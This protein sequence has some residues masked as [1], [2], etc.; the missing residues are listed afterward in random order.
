MK[1]LDELY[2]F[3][4]ELQTQGKLLNTVW[5]DTEMMIRLGSDGLSRQRFDAE[6][7]TIS[8]L[9]TS[10]LQRQCDQ[11]FGLLDSRIVLDAFCSPSQNVLK[12]AYLA[13]TVNE[14]DPLCL[15]SDFFEF[16]FDAYRR[17]GVFYSGFSTHKFFFCVP[18][19]LS[20]ALHTIRARYAVLDFFF[21]EFFWHVSDKNET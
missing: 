19:S 10:K 9:M 8:T 1:H 3:P 15:K 5:V 13:R 2:H 17:G 18:T 11:F 21:D 12:I 16:N 4:E 14:L 7:Y 20:C 6:G